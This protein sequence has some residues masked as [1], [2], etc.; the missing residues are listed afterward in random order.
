MRAS[1]RIG[2]IRIGDLEQVRIELLGGV[3]VVDRNRGVEALRVGHRPL[4]QLE[5]LRPD[6]S[7]SRLVPIRV[8]VSSITTVT[9]VSSAATEIRLVSRSRSIR[10][11]RRK[12]S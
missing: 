5:I 2:A 1:P 6:I 4:P 12:R 8:W 10:S 11:D 3:Q 9:K 7:L